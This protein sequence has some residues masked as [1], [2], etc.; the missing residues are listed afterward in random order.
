MQLLTLFLKLDANYKD[1]IGRDVIE[2]ACNT[3][4]E[5][6]AYSCRQS[7]RNAASDDFCRFFNI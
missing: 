7:E 6:Q 4:L 2:M 1:A 3:V 5:R